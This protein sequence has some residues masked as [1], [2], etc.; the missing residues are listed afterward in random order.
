MEGLRLEE[1]DGDI[2]EGSGKEDRVLER[3]KERHADHL[4]AVRRQSQADH[5]EDG[6]GRC[7][8]DNTS[9]NSLLAGRM[10]VQ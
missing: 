5:Q 6:A 4:L 3:S 8:E 2:V 9:D 10:V 1:A 7:L